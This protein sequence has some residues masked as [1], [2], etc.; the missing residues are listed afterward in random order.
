MNTG[1][2]S[3]MISC[4]TSL[5]KMLSYKRLQNYAF[6]LCLQY[7]FW[8]IRCIIEHWMVLNLFTPQILTLSARKLGLV[9][10]NKSLVALATLIVLWE[11]LRWNETHESK[12]VIL[13]YDT[14]N[15]LF[16][17]NIRFCPPNC[18]AFLGLFCRKYNLK[19]WKKCVRVLLI[20][21]WQVATHVGKMKTSL[22]VLYEKTF[23]YCFSSFDRIT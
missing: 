13:L 1:S 10:N 8:I 9:A 6:K 5:F 22:C 18:S 23:W 21:W 16:S 4:W 2:L 3:A 7:I 17:E 20:I 12:R 11:S 14:L 19:V 15:S